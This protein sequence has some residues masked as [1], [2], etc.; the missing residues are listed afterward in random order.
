MLSSARLRDGGDGHDI[1]EGQAVAGVRLDAVLGGERGGIGDALQLGRPLLALDMGVAAGVELDDRRA[2]PDRGLDLRF[3]RLDEQADADVRRAQPVD[4]I[5]QMVVLAGGV[6]PALGGPLLALSGTMQAACGLWR[7][8]IASISSVAAISRFSGR[9][10]SAISRSMS[11][12]V[13][14]RRSSRRWAVMPSAP[15][16]GGH[17]PRGPGRDAAAARVPDGRDMVDV[18]AEAER[19]GSRGG[20]A[21]GLDRRDRRQ[22]R[23]Q[24]VGGVGRDV[25]P[26]QRIE[27]HAE[28]DLPPERS[29]SAASAMTSPPA[30]SIAAIASR[31]DRPVVTTSSTISTR[32][33]GLEREAAAKLE[34]PF[35]PLDEHRRLAQRPAH[36][37]ADD[38]PAHRRR[39]DRVDR[40]AHPPGS[41]AASA[42][43]SRSARAGSIST[44]AHCR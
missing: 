26:D 29:T 25:D 5:G 33:A 10:I 34:R 15:G 14:W 18:D 8:A 22:L 21:P 11:S 27:R 41:L 39:D 24:V 6:E 40:L 13:M 28:V 31:D 1:V 44:R 36:F 38:H 17:A 43:A 20:A 16:L 7:R 23:R 9:S 19:A 2:E 4:E 32:C 42:R 30:S 3:G 12:S 37:M 35:G